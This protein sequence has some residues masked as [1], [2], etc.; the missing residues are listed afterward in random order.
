MEKVRI[1]FSYKHI[2][3]PWGGANNFIRALYQS[4]EVSEYFELVENIA[5]DYDILFMNELG[6][7]PVNGS[8]KMTLADVEKVRGNKKVV[9]RAV[10]LLRHSQTLRPWNYLKA[11]LADRDVI[12][13]LNMADFVVFQS[14][15][16]RSFFSHYGY[17]GKKNA[18]IHNGAPESFLDYTPRPPIEDGKVVL[19]SATASPRSTKRHDLIARMSEVE[20][21]EMIHFGRWPASIDKKKVI[22]HSIVPHED[23]AEVYRKA[24][25][26]FHPAVKDP[27]PNAVF[28]ALCAGLPVIY[29][30]GPGS[31][32]EIVGNNGV[33]LDGRNFSGTVDS[34]MKNYKNLIGMV[35]ETRPYYTVE[36]AKNQYISVFKS[37]YW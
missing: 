17:E 30:P 13:L 32:A 31:S 28:E 15:Y 18:I 10:N 7:G 23:M 6:L 33:P 20:N 35:G 1:C 14:D 27:C 37:L 22:L 25:F 9:V 4:M 11:W 24:H 5:D 21:V 2:D 36:R 3:A 19:V 16:Q 12:Q 34:A 26:F 29:H 8:S